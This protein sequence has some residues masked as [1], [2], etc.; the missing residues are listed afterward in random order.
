MKSEA[1]QTFKRRQRV[2]VASGSGSES[3]TIVRP[4]RTMAGWYV[5]R[6]DDA[7]ELCVSG[8]SLSAV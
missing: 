7:A 2:T 1:A 4:D 5:V 8:S 3:A 6:F